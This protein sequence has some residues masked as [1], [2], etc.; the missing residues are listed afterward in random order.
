MNVHY[1]NPNGDINL[2]RIRQIRM[3]PGPLARYVRYG[4]P[5]IGN[6][7][8][9][10]ARVM[11]EAVANFLRR[12]NPNLLLQNNNV[13]IVLRTRFY[14]G[15]G[16]A[17]GPWF[18]LA[19]PRL[20]DGVY[21]RPDG[22]VDYYAVSA[23]LQGWIMT[24]YQRRAANAGSD[25]G[26]IQTQRGVELVNVAVHIPDPPSGGCSTYS[27][28]RRLVIPC[29]SMTKTIT[30]YSPRSKNHN[31]AINALICCY[32]RYYRNN[33]TI[34][35]CLG[36][37]CG[38]HPIPPHMIAKKY[39]WLL[40]LGPN[41]PITFD[42]LLQLSVH[43][44]MHIRVM[45]NEGDTIFSQGEEYVRSCTLFLEES[46]LLDSH[47][48][49]VLVD[50][51]IKFKY[52]NTGVSEVRGYKKCGICGCR[53]RFQHDCSG[54]AGNDRHLEILDFYREMEEKYSDDEVDFHFVCKK[55]LEEN[56]HLLLSGPG[57]SGKSSLVKDMCTYM[58]LQGLKKDEIALVAPTGVAALNIGGDTINSF[59]SL[60]VTCDIDKVES[61][62]EK[63]LSDDKQMKKLISLRVLIV[64]EVSMWQGSSF[65]V[66][67]RLLKI[68]RQ[69]NMVFGGVKLILIGDFLQLAPIDDVFIFQTSLWSTV[70]EELH[71]VNLTKT[72]GKRYKE[73]E[74][75][76]LLSRL[77]RGM[78]TNADITFLMG[79]RIADISIAEKRCADRNL[80]LT[81]LL[82]TK[83]ELVN[84]DL[85]GGVTYYNDRALKLLPNPIKTLE[86]KDNFENL[87]MSLIP[88]SLSLCVGSQVMLL[89][90]KWKSEYNIVNGSQG[91]VEEI[92][93]DSVVVSFDGVN[94]S[95]DRI[96]FV[97]GSQVRYQFP[98]ILSY[99]LTI[100]KSQGKTLTA[101]CTSVNHK[102]F[103]PSQVY[104]ALSRV[105]S[106]R[107]LF[108]LDFDPKALT[109]S[110]HAFLFE[111]FCLEWRPGSVFMGGDETTLTDDIFEEI[112]K[113]R[114]TIHN[115]V[116]IQPKPPAPLLLKSKT[117]F[118]DLETYFDT[119]TSR[120][121]AYFCHLEDYQ[122]GSLVA[123]MD[124]CQMCDG[125]LEVMQA[126]YDYI[127]KRILDDCAIYKR[128]KDSG[129]KTNLSFLTKPIYLCAYNG[130]GF[131]FHFFLQYLMKDQTYARRFVSHPTM[132]GSKVIE[133]TLWDRVSQK[134][135]LKTHDVFNVTLCSLKNACKDFLSEEKMEKDI[136]PHLWI[137]RDRII[138]ANKVE[139]FSLTLSDF[140]SS[141]HPDITESKVDLSSFP[142]HKQLHKYGPLDVTLLVRLYEKIDELTH[143]AVDTSILRFSTL[144]K[145]SWYGFLRSLSSRYLCHRELNGRSNRVTL[146]HRMTIGEDKAVNES[147]VGGKCLP[148][149]M[150]FESKDV[151][152]KYED[153]QDY[154]VYLD[155][156]SMYVS[157]MMTRDFPYSSYYHFTDD[158]K[159]LDELTVMREQK[160][161]VAFWDP[162]DPNNRLSLIY[163]DYEFHPSELEPPLS[164]R[165]PLGNG[166]KSGH[167]LLWD[168]KRRSGW[169]TSIDAYLIL[170]NEGKIHSIREAYQWIERGPVFQ[171]WCQFTFQKKQE[172]AANNERSKKVFY[173]TIGNGCYGSAL[174]RTFT[175]ITS[176]VSQQD[177]LTR[178]HRKF[179]WLDTV[180]WEAFA[181]KEHAFLVL[182]GE[183]RIYPDYDWTARPRY[184][185]SFVL[186]W[187]R[188]MLD[189][190]MQ[191]VNPNRR[192]G[193]ITSIRQQ[194]I[195]GDTDSVMVPMSC[196]PRLTPFLG[197]EAG[198][199]G[200]E[201][202]DD[203]NSHDEPKFAKI[204]R[205]VSGAPKAYA[206]RA[207]FPECFRDQVK[208]KGKQISPNTYQYK[209]KEYFIRNNNLYRDVVK[210]KGI[211]QTGY[212]FEHKGEK[213]TEI[214]LD[215]LQDVLDE[216]MSIP[217]SMGYRILRN[218]FNTTTANFK[219]V[220]DFFN[221]HREEI[222]R[223][224]FKTTWEGR[225]RLGTGGLT[226][227]LSWKERD[228][229]DL[230]VLP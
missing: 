224:L 85:V 184:L 124:F 227:P 166:A 190:V 140:P 229:E 208:A 81:V 122:K 71:I 173:K 116:Q 13:Y 62:V 96:N 119:D 63:V 35:D 102:I 12:R 143:S 74:W 130:S 206:I 101:L 185:G 129:R 123:K 126:T 209:G 51:S 180:N 69:N 83:K 150:K 92:N 77:R 6:W 204:I 70:E 220:G 132:K 19:L 29:G 205:Y 175:S 94:V 2:H 201:L 112:S 32:K 30:L 64:D 28:E 138:Q 89:T 196:L 106:H 75:A 189:D 167:K 169:M 172:A 223:T 164:L 100:H 18:G 216:K 135:C 104:V 3:R 187:A 107:N 95:I 155:I 192:D 21:R 55:V 213:H 42:H 40:N 115:S 202:Y 148:R 188:L 120:E 113:I 128:V 145:M 176:I 78:C 225:R 215:I 221:I 149:M 200:D 20:N 99:A 141:M 212:N 25:Q 80:P 23:W 79:K 186:A 4:G 118:Y 222:S 34:V 219:Q 91:I 49:L 98:L 152:K 111:R 217:I 136:Y 156:V 226:V 16:E 194:P 43:F 174:Q 10:E 139:N 218:G 33:C 59:F 8:A 54:S 57:G 31:C 38:T 105:R 211:H 114:D 117:I 146:L 56:L 68:V 198:K 147:V 154:Y 127:M 157:V 9:D 179:D 22:S 163:A 121:V 162:Q 133:L 93:D 125:E 134:T 195:Y 142:V 60:G 159:Y 199:L 86:A 182:K 110:R 48:W 1:F 50:K 24:I 109:I 230:A 207:I 203:W 153:V 87:Q 45:N 37:E 165:V 177:D 82:P 39:R 46:D 90:N 103:T 5:D 171:S 27:H 168:I 197:D 97:Q 181:K 58:D 61:I 170:R 41:E 53:F 52:Q 65:L 47:Y 36:P 76:D 160:D 228:G 183:Q 144:S 72:H 108:L 88:K 214:T 44:K 193:T 11:A 178:F 151:D 66:V 131:D 26:L 210:L 84:G 191:A 7:M 17:Q 14:P 158:S 137:T 73:K 67:D 161:N 15:P